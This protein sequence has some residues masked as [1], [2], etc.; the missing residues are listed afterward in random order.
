MSYDRMF[1]EDKSAGSLDPAGL[2]FVGPQDASDT[3]VTASTKS[4][5]LRPA[6]FYRDSAYRANPAQK[7]LYGGST[8]T[9]FMV[10]LGG[11]QEVPFRV[12]AFGKLPA[13][14][15]ACA[16]LFVEKLMIERTIAEYQASDEPAGGPRGLEIARLADRAVEITQIIMKRGNARRM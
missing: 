4:K 5:P 9:V 12:E 14:R 3:P 2:D 11:P 10:R 15:K 6:T 8:V 16:T 7:R 13:D 1:V